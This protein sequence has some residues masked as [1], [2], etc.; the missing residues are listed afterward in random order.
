[1]SVAIDPLYLFVFAGLFSPGPN[2]VMLIA[3]GARFGFAPTV[4]HILGVAFGVGITA[5]LTGMGLGEALL[6]M[7]AVTLVLKIL[8]AIWIFYLA[9]ALFRST[10]MGQ[11]TEAA[12]PFT[13]F[14]AAL[15]QW[16]N[17]KVWAVALAA[18]AG[19]GAG[20]TGIEEG[21]RLAVAFSSI[22]LFV[23]IFWTAAGHGLTRF[24]RQPSI[25]RGFMTIMAGA[26]A[27]SGLLVFL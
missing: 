2:V 6:R 11:Q 16:V 7:P 14:Q 25:W 12:Q 26:L 22:N 24:L 19:F 1:M 20:G 21:T 4:P 18:G 5:G 27:L 17:P 13:F 23:C 8:A 3:S 9:W 10:R 15:F